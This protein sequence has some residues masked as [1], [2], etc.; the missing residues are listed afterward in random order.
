MTL[1]TRFRILSKIVA[2]LVLIGVMVAGGVWFAAGRMAHINTAYSA[3]IDNQ[4]QADATAPQL[5]GRSRN[6]RCSAT[7]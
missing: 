6:S 2:V 4:A 5:N 7:A 3:F 1:L